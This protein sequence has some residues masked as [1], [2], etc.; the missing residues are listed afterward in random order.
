[1]QVRVKKAKKA[2]RFPNVSVLASKEFG[3]T[4][5]VLSTRDKQHR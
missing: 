3:R 2:V 4:G 5:G 1:M